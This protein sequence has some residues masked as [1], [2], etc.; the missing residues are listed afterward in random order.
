MQIFSRSIVVRAMKPMNQSETLVVRVKVD[1]ESLTV[2]PY[3]MTMIRRSRTRG[4]LTSVASM[5]WAN[6]S[7][8][9]DSLDGHHV[10]WNEPPSSMAIFA[11]EENGADAV[12]STTKDYQLHL[13][14]DCERRSPC[15]EDGDTVETTITSALSPD[16]SVKITTEV[17]AIGSCQFSQAWA[18]PASPR[19]PAMAALR[20]VIEIKDVDDLPVAYTL[21]FVQLRVDSRLEDKDG[22]H[23]TAAAEPKGNSSIYLVADTPD[24]VMRSAGEHVMR[25]YLRQGWDHPSGSRVDCMLLEHRVEVQEMP[26]W[27]STNEAAVIG[28]AA[29]ISFVVFLGCCFVGCKWGHVKCMQSV[30]PGIGFSSR[31]VLFR[32]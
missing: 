31:T 10:I 24:L 2:L 1:A 20:F 14:L 3:S 17:Q 5:A 26:S 32:K 22:V 4:Q 30:L 13:R 19:M 9:D 15:I 29:G 6:L 18:D 21:P 11:L 23:V 8:P 12:T 25:I 7:R 27:G 16:E 28:I